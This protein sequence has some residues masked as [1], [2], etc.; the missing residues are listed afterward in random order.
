MRR[1]VAPPARGRDA[2]APPAAG[3]GGGAATAP[4]AVIRFP[5]S[6]G[7]LAR[8]PFANH[9]KRQEDAKLSFYAKRAHGKQYPTPPAVTDVQSK[10]R[11]W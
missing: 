2:A 11:P 5:F 8:E 10:K 9:Q 7:E 4:T 1:W 6:H 3:G